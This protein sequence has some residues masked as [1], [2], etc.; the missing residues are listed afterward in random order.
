MVAEIVL[1]D[2]HI[3]LWLLDVLLDVFVDLEV[4]SDI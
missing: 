1:E 2:H 4:A 3:V